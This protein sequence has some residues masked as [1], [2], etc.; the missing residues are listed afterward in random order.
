MAGFPFDALTAL[1]TATT[2]ALVIWDR[3]E[4]IRLPSPGIE[5]TME[6]LAGA[7]RHIQL[8]FVIRNPAGIAVRIKS[9]ELLSPR[10]AMLKGRDT[11]PV[12][13][14][15]PIV[16]AEPHSSSSFSLQLELPECFV[17]PAKLKI[18]VR[19]SYIAASM[20]DR[21][22]LISRVI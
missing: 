15:R 1:A 4:K 3:I 11:P 22:S 19:S 6:R 14:I 20:T 5:L 10:L 8:R 16:E 21:R 9:V 13:A 2:A 7:T 12:R 18:R 17:S